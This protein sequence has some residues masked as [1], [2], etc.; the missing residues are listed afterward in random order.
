MAEAERKYNEI[1]SSWALLSNK[2]N[3][4]QVNKILILTFVS[5]YS[6][7][8]ILRKAFNLWENTWFG[9]LN[10]FPETKSCQKSCIRPTLQHDRD[11]HVTGKM[12]HVWGHTHTDTRAVVSSHRKTDFAANLIVSLLVISLELK[13]TLDN[14]LSFWLSPQVSDD[15]QIPKKPNVPHM[16]LQNVLTYA[17][18]H[19]PHVPLVLSCL[20]VASGD[21]RSES[22][23]VTPL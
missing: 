15:R 11:T 16:A 12:A 1:I 8:T 2:Y 13:L 17:D 23:Q 10:Y 19:G 6:I 20:P 7:I 14:I 4:R 21:L 9:F 3:H 5:Y 22:A 18:F